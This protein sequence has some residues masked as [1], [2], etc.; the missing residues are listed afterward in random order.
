MKRSSMWACLKTGHKQLEKDLT[1]TGFEGGH[2][3]PFLQL[4]MAHVV[5]ASLWKPDL[6]NLTTPLALCTSDVISGRRDT[7]RDAL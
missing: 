3:L 1:Y 4:S 2:D 7:Y 5:Y 6:E